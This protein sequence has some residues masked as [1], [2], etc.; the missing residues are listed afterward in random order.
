VF[1][2]AVARTSEL[3]VEQRTNIKFPVKLGKSGSEIREMLMQVYRDKIKPSFI[4]RDFEISDL[5]RDLFYF[6]FLPLN[7]IC[8]YNKY[9]VVDNRQGVILQFGGWM[10]I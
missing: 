7:G 6:Y 4:I 1:W 3:E 8:E 2:C 10:L 9:E 5:I